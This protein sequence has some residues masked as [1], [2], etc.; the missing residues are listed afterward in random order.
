M[1]HRFHF[2][3]HA[4]LQ[5]SLWFVLAH[6]ALHRPAYC[7]RFFADEEAAGTPMAARQWRPDSHMAAGQ[8]FANERVANFRRSSEDLPLPSSSS[9]PALR[10]AG[11]NGSSAEAA[12][13]APSKKT[14]TKAQEAERLHKDAEFISEFLQALVMELAALEMHH[15]ANSE[16]KVAANIIASPEMLNLSQAFLPTGD[17]EPVLATSPVLQ[18]KLLFAVARNFH[19]W[20]SVREE[21]GLSEYQTFWGWVYHRVKDGFD[22][23]KL[24][25]GKSSAKFFFSRDVSSSLVLKGGMEDEY[26]EF[27]YSM[28]LLANPAFPMEDFYKGKSNLAHPMVSFAV[29]KGS[30][31][32]DCMK[33]HE[34]SPHLC[35]KHID[36][37]VLQPAVSHQTLCGRGDHPIARNTNMFDIKPL[38]SNLYLLAPVGKVITNGALSEDLGKVLDHFYRGGVDLYTLAHAEGALQV[39]KRDIDFLATYGLDDFSILL[40][41]GYRTEGNMSKHTTCIGGAKV[42]DKLFS[43]GVIDYFRSSTDS[44]DLTGVRRARNRLLRVPRK[45][46]VQDLT[47]VR[48][49]VQSIW[50]G[51]HDR[52]RFAIDVIFR[53]N[54]IFNTPADVS[55]E[56]RM[57]KIANSAVL[58]CSCAGR[59]SILTGT[60]SS[61]VRNAWIKVDTLR[62]GATG[63]TGTSSLM[64][65]CSNEDK[66]AAMS[67]CCPAED[68]ECSIHVNGF[69][70]GIFEAARYKQLMIQTRNQERAQKLFGNK[71]SPKPT[72]KPLPKPEKS[73]G[74]LELEPTQAPKPPKG[75]ASESAG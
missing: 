72:P 13:K 6:V 59:S 53:V 26:G 21:M 64:R 36:L 50:P 47:H 63:S 17:V 49:S 54:K 68:E 48:K 25:N 29:A 69:T 65:G 16:R 34:T 33:A 60:G 46:Y 23:K 74:N 37:Y 3:R 51:Y 9:E 44:V 4:Q 55:A 15:P 38:E 1:R 56:F 8:R 71:P 57:R 7:S 14:E 10:K 62:S 22:S 61:T 73:Q 20:K 39:L 31:Y 24:G 19:D 42:G 30:A 43:I 52:A 67:T 41:V 40:S 5:R 18:H 28:K 66:K 2:S 70:R 35:L 58:T 75:N 12:T 32:K 27:S 11:A 45:M